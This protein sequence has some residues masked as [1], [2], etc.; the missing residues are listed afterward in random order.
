VPGLDKQ[1]SEHDRFWNAAEKISCINL[2]S[3]Y[4]LI[5]LFKLLGRRGKESHALMV[6]TTLQCYVHFFKLHLYTFLSSFKYDQL[7]MTS[8]KLSFLSSSKLSLCT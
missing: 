6:K 4:L 2:L 7:A 3:I 8:Q 5:F 1:F